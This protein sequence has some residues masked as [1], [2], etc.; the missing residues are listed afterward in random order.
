MFADA[1]AGLVGGDAV[2]LAA[3]FDRGAG[4]HVPEIDVAGAAEEKHEDAGPGTGGAG[5]GGL[6]QTQQVAGAQA[7]HREP[8]D[9]QQV[10]ARGG[11]LRHWTIH[12]SH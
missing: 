8:A 6:S 3:D 5:G 9:F 10:P 4:F 12:E 1:D 11:V 2:E 7:Q